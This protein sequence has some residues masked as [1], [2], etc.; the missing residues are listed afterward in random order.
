MSGFLGSYLHQIDE[1]GRLSLPATFRREAAEH[2]MVLA[3]VHP[4]ALTLYPDAAWREVESRLRELLQRQPAA[5]PHVL[6]ITANA[7]EVV[8]DKQ[9][10]ILVPQRL[11][12]AAGLDGSA[13][14]VGAIDRVEIWN[15]ER[16]EAA[17][18]GSSPDFARFTS[19]IFA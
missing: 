11:M 14:L 5:R 4:D 10:R 19:Q 6:G 8:P 18:A 17:V 13:L 7:S 2:A 16:F 15:P 9:G 12:A 1:K 3:Q